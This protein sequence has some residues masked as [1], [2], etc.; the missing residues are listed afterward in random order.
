MTRAQLEQILLAGASLTPRS[1]EVITWRVLG[2]LQRQGLVRATD[3][4]TGGRA[5]GSSR[6]AYFLT[7]SGL[8]RA[9]AFYPDIPRRRPAARGAFLLAHSLLANEVE[10]ALRQ[11]AAGDLD[12]ELQLWEPDWQIRLHFGGGAAI[13]PD[14]RFVYRRGQKRLHGFVEVDLGTEG[15]RFFAKKIPRYIEL[16]RY[17]RWRSFIPVWPLVLTVTPTDTRAHSL[18]SA[19]SAALRYEYARPQTDNTF[20]FISIDELRSGDALRVPWRVA[21]TAERM[22]L[23]PADVD[24][25]PRVTENDGSRPIDASRMPPGRSGAGREDDDETPRSSHEVDGP[26]R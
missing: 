2:R 22:P 9:A 21:G 11:A 19:T 24:A 14:A 1:R 10:L 6:P 13:V 15:T 12:R 18:C 4:Q 26:A 25:A 17:G 23:W 3:R 16:H 20:R 8:R 7:A 5:A